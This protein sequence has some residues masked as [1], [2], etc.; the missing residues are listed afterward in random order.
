[1]VLKTFCESSSGSMVVVKLIREIIIIVMDS[2]VS[3]HAMY[4][5]EQFKNISWGLV[6]MLD[7]LSI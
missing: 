1:M 4:F 7:S 5:G 3:H 6:I 2:I